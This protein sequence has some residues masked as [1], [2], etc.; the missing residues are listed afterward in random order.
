MAPVDEDEFVKTDS[1]VV[2]TGQKL[3][4]MGITAVLN[5]GNADEPAV[6]VDGVDDSIITR[7][8]TPKPL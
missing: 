5:A 1:G 8:Y 4:A 7:A 3:S 2:A 6:V